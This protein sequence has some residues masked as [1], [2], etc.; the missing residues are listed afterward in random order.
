MKNVTII[1][2]VVEKNKKIVVFEYFHDMQNENDTSIKR[3]ESLN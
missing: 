1:Y 3:H 2:I